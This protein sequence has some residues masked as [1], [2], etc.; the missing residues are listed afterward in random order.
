VPSPA[1]ALAGF[2]VALRER[3]FTA[4]GNG[5]LDLEGVRR[6]L[7]RSGYAG[8]L[9]VEQDSSWLPPAEAAMVGRRVV[10]FARRSVLSERVG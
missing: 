3:I 9:M 10:E 4:P 5:V 1:G 6:A 7:E 8:W 2:G